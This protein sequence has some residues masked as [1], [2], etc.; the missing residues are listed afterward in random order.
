MKEMEGIK[1]LKFS[2]EGLNNAIK[3]LTQLKPQLQQMFLNIDFEGQGK[4]DAEEIGE[5][6]TTAINAMATVLVYMGEIDNKG[7]IG[8]VSEE[9]KEKIMQE[10][11]EDLYEEF[12]QVA[13]FKR[14][15]TMK[16]VIDI[17]QLNEESD[18]KIVIGQKYKLK[19]S[20]SEVTITSVDDTTV[21]VIFSS[22]FEGELKISS[23]DI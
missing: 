13:R 6:F 22:G 19:D 17:L 18:K 14:K 1:V 5:H 4:K 12:N 16:D 11:A 7:E 21:G 2:K 23:L 15:I 8:E 9:T 20:K 10:Y 3:G